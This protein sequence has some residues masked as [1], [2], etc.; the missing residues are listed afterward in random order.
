MII[1][2]AAFYLI[3]F[4]LSIFSHHMLQQNTDLEKYHQ[5]VSQYLNEHDC[6]LDT[7]M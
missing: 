5:T 2:L 4:K 3:Y 6:Y 7:D 1:G